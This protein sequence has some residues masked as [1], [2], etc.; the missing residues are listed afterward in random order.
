MVGLTDCWVPN[1]IPQERVLQ[2]VVQIEC[3]VPNI[4]PQERVLENGEQTDCQMPNIIP[5]ER[6]TKEVEQTEYV[7]QT[8]TTSHS[9]ATTT[10]IDHRT[11]LT[12]HRSEEGVSTIG[13]RRCC[14]ACGVAE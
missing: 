10:T 13:L 1:I 8:T 12:A 3:L 11:L 7:E 2:E 4:I 5:Q 9:T 6:A 14:T